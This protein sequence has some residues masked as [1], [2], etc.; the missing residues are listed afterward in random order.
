MKLYFAPG[1]CSLS[2]HIVLRELEL[3]VVLDA[4]SLSDRRTASGEDFA[5]INPKGYVPA[6]AL[7]DGEVLTEGVAIIQYLADRYA[8]GRLAP[9]AGTVERARV[10]GWLN[11][12][13]S[14]LHKAFSPLFNPAIDQAAREAAVANVSRRL[15]ILENAL[16]DGRPY[17]TGDPLTLADIH[18][19]V[20]AG[21]APHKGIDLSAW[22]NLKALVDRVAA[23]PAVQAAIAA[24]TQQAQAA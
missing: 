10:Q 4:V 9:P 3:P 22:P 1:A 8:P 7:D 6:L 5:A 17:L 20:I 23:R 21:W 14:E 2:P 24:E 16:S 19:F 13:T 18:L 15:A 12:I 11:F